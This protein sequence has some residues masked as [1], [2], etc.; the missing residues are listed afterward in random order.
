MTLEFKELS[1]F[2]QVPKYKT[3][4]RFHS[5]EQTYPMH[6]NKVFKE[7]T[8][9]ITKGKT[10]VAKNIHIFTE[11]K[12]KNNLLPIGLNKYCYIHSTKIIL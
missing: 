2:Q 11:E 1:E 4:G 3:K 9:K 10:L 6:S 7:H 12:N 8:G 5:F